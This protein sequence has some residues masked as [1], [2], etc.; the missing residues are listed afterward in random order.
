MIINH[1][2]HAH[3]TV[4]TAVLVGCS[5]SHRR[6]PK[7]RR[8]CQVDHMKVAHQIFMSVNVLNRT[9]VNSLATRSSLV[10]LLAFFRLVTDALKTFEDTAVGFSCF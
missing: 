2:W 5:G 6:D 4:C 10:L 8:S 3:S 1:H 7:T 9:H